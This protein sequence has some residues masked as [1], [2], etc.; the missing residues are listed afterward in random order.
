MGIF[1]IFKKEEKKVF[2]T[3]Q[4][5]AEY[6]LSNADKN[7]IESNSFSVYLNDM[8]KLN[9]HFQEFSNL[10]QNV[11]GKSFYK[12]NGL[13]NYKSIIDYWND[14]KNK[15]KYLKK[16]GFNPATIMM[17]IV[18]FEIEKQII[19]IKEIS[20]DILNF[21]ENDKESEIEADVKT[22]CNI[23]EEYKYN[24]QDDQYI[25]NNHKYVMD[26]ERTALK[27]IKFY[28]KQIKDETSKNSLLMTNKTIETNQNKIEHDFTYYRLSL[29]IY[30]FA[31]FLEVMLLEN[32]NKDF[33][34]LKKKELDNLTNEYINGYENAFKYIQKNADK[35]LQGNIISGIG[36]AGKVI[37]NLAEKVQIVKN[38][39]IDTWFNKNGD[40][41]K[42]I[43]KERKEKLSH[44][45]EEMGNPHTST[46]IDKIE[47]ISKLYNDTKDI[48]F[49]KEKIYLEMIK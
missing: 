42:N 27:N 20:Q 32:F 33:L 40:N 46:F 12:L 11:D 4:E 48:Y 7:K 8:T 6:L 44:K 43:S 47:L 9:N 35:S 1:D 49:D 21:L 23:I 28:I 10:F 22:L 29:Y 15:I 17:T 30:S 34:L 37:G 5:E 24:W 25:H 26:I 3:T 2:E 41:L 13:S 16:L 45:F 39:K 31:T 19:E 14:P 36:S 38:A 18:L